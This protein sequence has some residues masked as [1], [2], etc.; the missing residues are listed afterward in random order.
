MLTSVPETLFKT[1][2]TKIFIEFLWECVKVNAL[3]IV[4]FNILNKKFYE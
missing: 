3:K 1:L 2:N 4:M